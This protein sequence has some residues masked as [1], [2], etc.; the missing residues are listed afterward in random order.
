MQ[1][2]QTAALSKATPTRRPIPQLRSKGNGEG[3]QTA[4]P[5]EADFEPDSLSYVIAEGV[6]T[7]VLMTVEDYERLMDRLMVRSAIAKLDDPNTEYIDA[8]EAGRRLAADRIIN[9]RK[10]A[11]LTQKQL[12]DKLGL[13]QSQISRIERSPDHTTVRTMKKIAKAL[14]VDVSALVR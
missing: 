6:P 12:G 4:S 1:K 3:Q 2:A 9:A 7:H 10:A 14:G 11:G 8:W 13:P 5:S